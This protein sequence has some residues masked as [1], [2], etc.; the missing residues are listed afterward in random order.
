MSSFSCRMAYGRAKGRLSEHGRVNAIDIGGFLTA[1]GKT[2]AVAADWG[3]VAREIA[4]QAAV[5]QV[6][7]ERQQANSAPKRD[8]EKAA[9]PATASAVPTFRGTMEFPPVIVGEPPS[10]PATTGLGWAP[11]RLGG[12]KPADAAAADD[13]KANFLRAAH[14]AA[15]TI[16]ATVLGPEANKAHKNH[17]HLDMSQRKS[18]SICE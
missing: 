18:A 9:Q 6:D 7:A 14:R 2:A 17:F 16:F 13:G 3:P 11:S 12:P 4:A 8:A 15:C 5:A 1:Q 10:R